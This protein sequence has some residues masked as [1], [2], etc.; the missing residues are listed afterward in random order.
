LG[1]ALNPI[2][3]SVSF[4]WRIETLSNDRYYWEVC[5]SSCH[6]IVFMVFWFFRV[7]YGCIY[8]PLL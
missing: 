5:L 1:L 3:Q 2:H 8:L 6:S 7:S 4:G